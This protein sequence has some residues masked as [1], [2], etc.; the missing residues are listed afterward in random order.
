MVAVEEGPRIRWVSVL[1]AEYRS[2]VTVAVCN[3]S[4][5]PT[6]YL[7]VSG[8]WFHSHSGPR[9]VKV[10]LPVG[11]FMLRGGCGT[12]GY[13]YELPQA[14]LTVWRT[15]QPSDVHVTGART[16]TRP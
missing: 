15:G 10:S 2:L 12:L 7:V 11:G 9:T 4:P 8:L 16:G 14:P 13:A 1:R 6:E 5:L 3:R